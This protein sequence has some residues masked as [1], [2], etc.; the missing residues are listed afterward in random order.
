MHHLVQLSY[1][2]VLGFAER[3]ID[4]VFDINVAIQS[5]KTAANTTAFYTVALAEITY[6]D[7]SSC[8][9]IQSYLGLPFALSLILWSSFVS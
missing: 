4:T 3:S 5:F 1:V 9:Y 6:A 2:F 8:A 7:S